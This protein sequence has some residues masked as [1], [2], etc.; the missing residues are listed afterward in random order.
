MGDKAISTQ[1]S[2]SL[3]IVSAV[4]PTTIIRMKGLSPATFLGQSIKPSVAMFFSAQEMILSIWQCQMILIYL[5]LST[6][7]HVIS[8]VDWRLF[9][10]FIMYQYTKDIIYTFP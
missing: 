8:S 9:A 7:Q 4:T 3:K 5:S 2:Y 10:F 6:K 1:Q